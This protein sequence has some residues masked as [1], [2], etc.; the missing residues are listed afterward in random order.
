MDKSDENIQS[1][2][3]LML[4]YCSGLQ[5][6]LEEMEKDGQ[7]GSNVSPPL[8]LNLPDD[9]SY[10]TE[11]QESTMASWT[12]PSKDNQEEEQQQEIQQPADELP[13]IINISKNND[14][15]LVPPSQDSVGSCSDSALKQQLV[16][17]RSETEYLDAKEMTDDDENYDDVHNDDVCEEDEESI[18][19]QAAAQLMEV[20][21]SRSKFEKFLDDV[22]TELE[23]DLD[24]SDNIMIDTELANYTEDYFAAETAKL[25]EEALLAK[26]IMSDNMNRELLYEGNDERN[27]QAMSNGDVE[28]LSV[29]KTEAPEH[30][31]NGSAVSNARN[32]ETENRDDKVNGDDEQE[33]LAAANSLASQLSDNERDIAYQIAD[34]LDLVNQLAKEIEIAT[35]LSDGTISNHANDD[36]DE[37]SDV[38]D[39]MTNLVSDSMV[40][41]VTDEEVT[42]ALKEA[43]DD[44][45]EE[46]TGPKLDDTVTQP[47]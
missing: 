44:L 13:A 26:N 27:E 40:E 35:Q 16:R 36:E 8:S 2:A 5:R 38:M 10:V 33:E 41:D 43:C 31:M 37:A 20:L 11:D 22:D 7:T 30:E 9:H 14:E 18:N 12:Q 23:K 39:I 32:D 42:H 19:R 1:L 3:V 28:I 21:K 4:H 17:A 47:T 25:K 6:C 34:E 15:G 24:T 29:D 46:E 45:C